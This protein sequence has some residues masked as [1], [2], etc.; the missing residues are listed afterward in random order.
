VKSTKKYYLFAKV[1]TDGC[2]GFDVLGEPYVA[3]DNRSFTNADAPQ[4]GSS[5]VDY[6]V[7]FENRVTV[8]SLNRFAVFVERKAAGAKGNS[9][10]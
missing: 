10:V 2:A 8:D 7:I 1:C 4:E 5:R 3:A 6:Y 9:L